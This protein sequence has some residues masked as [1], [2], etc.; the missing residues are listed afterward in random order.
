MSVRAVA[1]VRG[2]ETVLSVDKADNDTFV[3]IGCAT[4]INWTSNIAMLEAN[5]YSGKE[6]L[7]SG[8]NAVKSINI[9]GV[10]KEYATADVATNVSS[11]ELELW[12]DS[13]AL[14]SFKY[15]RPHVGDVVREFDGF[16][17]EYSEEGAPNGLQ[18]YAATITPQ[19]KGTLTEVPAV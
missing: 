3:V 6:M 14:K 1:T 10:V 8:D 4:Q 19:K 12:H 5:C 7:P 17:T 11:Y 13:G 15:A 16:V 9:T 18:T 2:I